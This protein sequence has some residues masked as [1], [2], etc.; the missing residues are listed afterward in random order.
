MTP[1]IKSPREEAL[2]LARLLVQSCCPGIKEDA[3]EE[4]TRQIINIILRVNVSTRMRNDR[5]E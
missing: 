2:R 5:H 3:A 4:A 1:E